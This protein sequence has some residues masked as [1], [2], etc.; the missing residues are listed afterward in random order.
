MVCAKP[1][2]GDRRRDE[3]SEFTTHCSKRTLVQNANDLIPLFILRDEVA[4]VED[5][6]QTSRTEE[7][8]SCLKESFVST[9]LNSKQDV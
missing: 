3:E 1:G 7:W 5:A 6:S 2:F 9:T 8:T 4:L